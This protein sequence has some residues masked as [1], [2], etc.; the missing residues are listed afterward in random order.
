VALVSFGNSGRGKHEVLAE[1]GGSQATLQEDETPQFFLKL[2]PEEAPKDEA[3][4]SLPSTRSGID[5]DALGIVPSRPSRAMQ[6][7]EET[8]ATNN[9]EKSDIPQDLGGLIQLGAELLGLAGEA[10]TTESETESAERENNTLVDFVGGVLVSASNGAYTNISI[11]EE[12]QEV[13]GVIDAIGIMD[14]NDLSSL[15]DSFG[16]CVFCDAGDIMPNQVLAGM[17]CSDWQTFSLLATEDECAVLRAVAVESCG[18]QPKWLEAA[19]K[20]AT[21]SLCLDGSLDGVQLDTRIPTMSSAL[22][23]QDIAHLP[24][25]EGEKTCQS[26]AAFGYVCGCPGTKPQCHLCSDGSLPSR[27]QAILEITDPENSGLEAVLQQNAGGA[28]G[29]AA[30]ARDGED[31]T[32]ASLNKALSVYTKSACIRTIQEIEKASGLSIPAFC[33]CAAANAT[34]PKKELVVPTE[35]VNL[36]GCDPC[37]AGLKLKSTASFRQDDILSHPSLPTIQ[38]CKEWVFDYAPFLYNETK[39]SAIQQIVAGHCCGPLKP[40][41]ERTNP[42]DEGPAALSSSASNPLTFLFI[43]LFATSLAFTASLSQ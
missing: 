18:C 34:A 15:M 26:V 35:T 13:A 16:S 1:R 17:K 25:V 39:C 21:C 10:G 24:A 6:E 38:S 12:L 3:S 29:R 2:L 42:V 5:S 28:V 11:E 32:C 7:E 43:S 14:P 41:V 4:F 8:P 22:S 20:A 19:A 36:R 37:P 30:N 23:C 27:P 31:L 40:E 9:G 33:G